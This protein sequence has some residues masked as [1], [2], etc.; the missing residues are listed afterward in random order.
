ML[1][2]LYASVVRPSWQ[3]QCCWRHLSGVV[4]N[5]VAKLVF[6]YP[7]VHVECLYWKSH[8]IL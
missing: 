6:Q 2:D 1:R 4:S 7:V 3:R 8:R 5:G